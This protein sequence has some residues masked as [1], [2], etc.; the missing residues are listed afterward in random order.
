[1]RI[2]VA[3]AVA[4]I[5]IVNLG[6]LSPV[7][8]DGYVTGGTVAVASGHKSTQLAQANPPLTCAQESDRCTRVC[9]MQW[10][11][12]PPSRCIDD[13]PILYERC[14]RDT[15]GRERSPGGAAGSHVLPATH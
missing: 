9:N 12:S 4:V 1:M 10:Q 2:T 8:A 13:C 11:G 3:L 5:A 14:V 7:S 15:R 6:A